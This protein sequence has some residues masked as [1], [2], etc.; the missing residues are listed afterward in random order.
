M[1]ILEYNGD[2]ESDGYDLNEDVDILN[3]NVKEDYEDNM[4]ENTT[5]TTK[6]I[7]VASINESRKREHNENSLEVIPSKKKQKLAELKVCGFVF[8][9]IQKKRKERNEQNHIA[10]NTASMELYEQSAYF[11]SFIVLE[12]TNKQFDEYGIEFPFEGILQLI[13][14]IQI[15]ISKNLNSHI[16]II[17]FLI[18]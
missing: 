14:L 2:S 15:N 6:E 11:W 5:S 18:E 17:N 9:I 7:A 3:N 16:M 8:T 12:N 13:F 1:F 10:F 4:D